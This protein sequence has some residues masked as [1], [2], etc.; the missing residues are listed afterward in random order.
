MEH[1]LDLCRVA[2]VIVPVLSCRSTNTQ[3]LALDPYGS[4]KAF[5]DNGYTLLN[6]LKNQGIPST[7]SVIQ[8]L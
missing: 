5:D 2:D 7:V 3:G 4:G 1:L 6:I 8:H